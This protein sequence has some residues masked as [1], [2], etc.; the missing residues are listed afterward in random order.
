MKFKKTVNLAPTEK[1]LNTLWATV[2][3]ARAGWKS[4]WSGKT[5]RLN[6]HHIHGKSNYRLRFEL[7]NGV[8]ITSG[9]H[10]YIAHHSGRSAKFKEWAINLH[11]LDD[12]MARLLSQQVG[13]VDKMAVLLYLEG[14]LGKYDG[15]K[16]D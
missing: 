13:G 1:E 4:E 3:K 7:K 14:E 8:C 11:G 6:A 15:K 16:N 10:K 5:E 12:S 9:E 2:I